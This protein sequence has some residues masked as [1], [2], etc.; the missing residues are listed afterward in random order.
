MS[1]AEVMR[2]GYDPLTADTFAPPSDTCD[3]GYRSPIFQSVTLHNNIGVNRI[4]VTTD[5]CYNSDRKTEPRAWN[6]I[7][8]EGAVFA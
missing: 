5:G 1:P 4:D 3:S 7:S 8:T 6:C 2:L